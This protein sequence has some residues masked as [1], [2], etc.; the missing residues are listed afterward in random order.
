MIRRLLELLK[1]TKPRQPH[2][3]QTD[4]SSSASDEDWDEDDYYDEEW[5]RE[6]IMERREE[7]LAERAATCSCGA[8]VFGKDG[9]VYH[10]ADC[11]CGAE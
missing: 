2:L 5:E 7:E 1:L 11:C 9:K 6:E 8:W 4:V 10:V 3:Q